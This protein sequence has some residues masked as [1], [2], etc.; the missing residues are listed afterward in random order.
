LAALAS[1]C[2]AAS[3]TRVISLDGRDWRVAA[4]A[5][6]SGWRE[7]WWHEPRPEAVPVRVPWAMQDALPGYHG[8]AWYWREFTAP[9]HPHPDGRYLLRF[10]AVNYKADVW[11]NDV[12]LGGDEGGEMP[13]EFDVTAAVRPG[14]SQQ[15]A[16]RVLDPLYDRR[17]DGMTKYETPRRGGPAIQHG[18]IEDS[19]ELLLVP[20]ARVSDVFVRPNWRTG[21][22]GLELTFVNASQRPVTAK[23]MLSVTRDKGETA[24]AAKS[25]DVYLKPGKSMVTE[26]LQIPNPQLWDLETPNLHR[27]SARLSPSGAEASEA[28]SVRFGFRDFRFEGG[29]FRLNGKRILLK[30][31][32]V[33][34]FDALGFLLPYDLGASPDFFERR[35]MEAKRLG[36][37]MVRVHRGAARR[38][39]LDRADEIGLMIYE[40]SFAASRTAPTP[41]LADRLRH[42]FSR[43]VR[44]DRNHPSVVA[45]GLLN[46]IRAE[47]PQFQEGVAALSLVRSL[48]QTRMVI[49]NSGRWD[50]LPHIGSL[51]NPGSLEWQ[52]LLGNERPEAKTALAT[53]AASKEGD[54]ANAADVGDIHHYVGIPFSAESRKLFRS[55]GHS[56]RGPMLVSEF[57]TGSGIDLPALWKF[58]ETRGATHLEPA[59]FTRRMLDEF[60]VDWK[61]YGLAETFSGPADFF[62]QTLSRSARTRLELINALRANPK[63][64][65]FSN[66]SLSERPMLAQGIVTMYGETKPGMQEALRDALAPA[67]FSLFTEPLSCYT[68]DTVRLEA[69]LANVG[70]VPAGVHTMIVEVRDE[71]GSLVYDRRVQVHVGEGEAPFAQPVLSE[72]VVMT[73]GGG[74]YRFTAR[75]AGGP[76]IP[77]G[78]SELFV[79]DRAKMPAVTSEV[80]LWGAD[81]KLQD[82]LTRNNIRWRPFDP[83]KPAAR[84]LIVASKDP[85]APGGRAAFEALFER[86]AQGASVVFLSEKVFRGGKDPTRW[87]PLERKGTILRPFNWLLTKDEWIKA[88]PIFDGLQRGGILEYPYYRELLAAHQPIFVKANAPDAAIAGALSTSS[89]QNETGIYYSGLLVA[90]YSFGSGRFL[91]NG[92]MI[93][94]QLGA[95]P[96]AERLLRNMLRHMARDIHRPSA[97]LTPG[98][99]Q[100]IVHI[101]DTPGGVP[102]AISIVTPHP[103]AVVKAPGTV[104]ITIRAAQLDRKVKKVEFFSNGLK[105]GEDTVRKQDLTS[106]AFI[107]SGIN[108]GSYELKARAVDENG[109]QTEA[110]P[111]RIRVD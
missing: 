10:G 41:Y 71:A 97:R 58:Y 64:A 61:L 103:G 44:R 42:A 89:F 102:P 76:E 1:S 96:Q 27:L 7:Q 70:A 91:I 9:V 54:N 5:G 4:D 60:L 13:F 45:W 78:T 18:G 100:K 65:G 90:E 51:S 40:E 106:Y 80:V 111:V 75:V 82:W 28:A 95:S 99:K 57:G 72:D 46:E 26:S 25:A 56:S 43:L 2:P 63:I 24:V 34:N 30:T 66:V 48:D 3:G 39:M 107:W 17:I 68:G 94:D 20:T 49:L 87:L 14:A 21:D 59:Q 50:N 37:N 22:V 88:H 74:R 15:L 86:M 29:A 69:V 84:E 83:V 47:W 23:L 104:A 16:V 53:T 11:L 67:R 62:K 33:S 110:Q 73:G 55:F 52:H 38:N 8:V 105:I 108:A 101:L 81:P 79:F 98:V 109:G 92:L 19:V 36:F 35:L 6:D 12:Y 77:G 85:P 31:A 93:R 32:P